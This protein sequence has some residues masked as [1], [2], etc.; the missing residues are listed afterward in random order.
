MRD[1]GDICRSSP[2]LHDLP[3]L[4]RLPIDAI[5]RLTPPHRQLAAGQRSRHH[6][7]YMWLPSVLLPLALVQVPQLELRLL[8]RL[9][10]VRLLVVGLPLA[11][12]L[13][14]R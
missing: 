3:T 14:W 6:L 4:Q 1:G 11:A 7:P 5:T 13:G 12:M 8:V 2:T 9:L 10:L